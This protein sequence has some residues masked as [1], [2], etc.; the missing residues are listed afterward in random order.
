MTPVAKPRSLWQRRGR[1]ART[2][3]E[4]MRR[5]AQEGMT[6]PGYISVVIGRQRRSPSCEGENTRLGAHAL[7]SSVDREGVPSG[8]KHIS[9]CNS[10]R[11][12]WPFHT[13]NGPDYSATSHISTRCF[14][15]M[16]HSGKC[17]TLKS[18]KP[19]ASPKCLHRTKFV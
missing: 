17:T 8:A 5:G 16:H 19:G 13:G 11:I 18:G 15:E 9:A 6:G 3:W 12:C 2:M 10:H 1:K 14:R 7:Y 4:V